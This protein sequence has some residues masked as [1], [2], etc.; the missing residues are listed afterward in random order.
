MYMRTIH[1]PL[2][3]LAICWQ[4]AEL[5]FQHAVEIVD[6]LFRPFDAGGH[7][8]H[9]KTGLVYQSRIFDD[10]EVDEGHLIDVE[11]KIA[12]KDALPT[13]SVS[14]QL[15][16]SRDNQ[17]IPHSLLDNFAPS[18]EISFSG[19]IFKPKSDKP[20]YVPFR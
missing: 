7:H 3:N 6:V 1:T 20:V 9:R 4:V 16:F 15:L 12:L 11:M 13:R 18:F 19:S 17:Y 5:S 8:D 10:S 2:K 14:I